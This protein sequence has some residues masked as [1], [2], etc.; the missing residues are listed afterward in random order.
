MQLDMPS[1]LFRSAYTLPEHPTVILYGA[2]NVGHDVHAILTQSGGTVRCFLDRHAQPGA[3]WQGA[4]I[5]SPDDN[6]LTP[7]ECASLPV[8]VTI[9]NRDTDILQIAQT[10]TGLGYGPCISFVDFHARFPQ[11]LGDRFWLTGRDYYAAYAPAIAEAESLWADETSQRLY[12][13]LIE[14]RQ[15]GDYARLPQPQGDQYFFHDIPGW[16]P[17]TPLRFVDCGAYDG[18]TLTALAN[19]GLPVGAIAGFEPDLVSFR[20]LAERAR[21]YNP[22]PQDGIALWPC[23]VT[24]RTEQLA[25]V[26]GHG[27][28]SYL[29]TE[30]NTVIQCVALDDVLYSF[31]PNLIK[32]DIEG[33]EPDALQGAREIIARYRPGLAV[34]VYHR[35]N[36][37]WEIL[38]S[39]HH[40]RLDYQ[41]Y[42]RCHAQNSFDVV[43]Y[44]VPTQMTGAF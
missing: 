5:F 33:A 44:A 31:C 8:I 32:M 11:T 4:P 15:T 35:P 12:T 40:W 10:L 3:Q 25:F 24:A 29:G 1:T 23:G 16:P 19:T 20:Q 18:D 39:L 14:F 26:A 36:H 6:P 2:G 9:F 28:G 21:T 13:A 38:L 42:L 30:G 34:C 7:E 17:A 37:L 27:E 22:M 43:L 41:F